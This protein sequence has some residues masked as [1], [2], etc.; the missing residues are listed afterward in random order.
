MTQ[1]FT[2]IGEYEMCRFN[3]RDPPSSVYVADWLT[4]DTVERAL[5][6]YSRWCLERHELWITMMGC[7]VSDVLE[8][9]EDM[10]VTKKN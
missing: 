9:V 2:G 5:L 7:R 4:A 6:L 8:L 10:F 3:L 1:V